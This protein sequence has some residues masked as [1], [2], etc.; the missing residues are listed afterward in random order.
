[1]ASISSDR[2]EQISGD[3]VAIRT[4]WRVDLK[5]ATLSEIV[6]IIRYLSDEGVAVNKKA[7]WGRG[8]A[9]FTVA[10]E[11]VEPIKSPIPKAFT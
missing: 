9:S 3:S 10:A 5:D 4:T 2:K 8:G 11:K 1:M 6:Q 7:N